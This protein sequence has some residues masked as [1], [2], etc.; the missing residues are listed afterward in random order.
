MGESGREWGAL[1]GGSGSDSSPRG[2]LGAG[3]TMGFRTSLGNPWRDW[4]CGFGKDTEVITHSP[5]VCGIRRNNYTWV[6][7]SP[8]EFPAAPKKMERTMLWLMGPRSMEVKREL[9]MEDPHG[10][11]KGIMQLWPSSIYSQGPGRRHHMWSNSGISPHRS[12][13]A[14]PQTHLGQTL[15]V[16]QELDTTPEKGE[17]PKMTGRT[18]SA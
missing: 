15:E 12:T 13:P 1:S 2:I 18:R 9:N 5:D 10:R 14:S 3:G 6:S 16:P 17:G 4:S 8:S 7:G 11:E